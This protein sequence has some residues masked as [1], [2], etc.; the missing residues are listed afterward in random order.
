MDPN[1]NSAP[2]S[3]D[4]EGEADYDDYT[5]DVNTLNGDYDNSD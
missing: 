4:E 5:D 3:M 1:V 2:S